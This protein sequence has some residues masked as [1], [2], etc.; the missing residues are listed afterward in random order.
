MAGVLVTDQR[1]LDVLDRLDRLQR[2][3]YSNERL[4]ALCNGS[5]HYVQIWRRLR[6]VGG[7]RFNSR[8]RSMLVSGG[9]VG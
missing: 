3:D 7:C 1:R 5:V 8:R 4:A 6:G 2:P 9:G